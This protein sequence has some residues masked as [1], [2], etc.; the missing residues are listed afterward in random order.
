[1]C[2]PCVYKIHK[3]YIQKKN[4]I[5]VRNTVKDRLKMIKTVYKTEIG[6]ANEEG[7]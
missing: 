2:I 4:A 3:W 6:E 5:F 7:S 1:M